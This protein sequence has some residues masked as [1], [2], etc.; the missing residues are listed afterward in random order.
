MKNEPQ[1]LSPDA[2]NLEPPQ[3]GLRSFPPRERWSDWTEYDAAA[4]PKRVERHY[5][6][7]PTICFNCEAGCGLLAY[8]GTTVS[9]AWTCRARPSRRNGIRGR[10][11]RAIRR[12]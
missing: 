5:N 8:V 12:R 4:W 6:L 11:S 7:I 3:G 10:F 1:P 9:S 2:A